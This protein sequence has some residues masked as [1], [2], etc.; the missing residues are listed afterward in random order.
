MPKNT[1]FSQKSFLQQ[2]RFM[3]HVQ[4]WAHFVN[5]ARRSE[6]PWFSL[7]TLVHGVVIDDLDLK[8]GVFNVL[9]QRPG[10]SVRGSPMAKAAAGKDVKN[11]LTGSFAV[12]NHGVNE[13][14]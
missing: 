4:V 11:A 13:R 3:P 8:K 5:G 9:S 6:D 2:D 10:I 7:A 1:G 12:R 14:G